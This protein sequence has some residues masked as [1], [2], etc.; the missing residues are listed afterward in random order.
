MSIEG[1]LRC[2]G[3]PVSWLEAWSRGEEARPQW[4][5][6]AEEWARVEDRVRQSLGQDIEPYFLAIPHEQKRRN[7]YRA[8]RLGAWRLSLVSGPKRVSW[9]ESDVVLENLLARGKVV[10]P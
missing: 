8:R 3:F 9:D 4:W 6:I 1:W 2:P 10:D 7:E 5:Q